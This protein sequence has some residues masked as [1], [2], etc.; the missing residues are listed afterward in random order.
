LSIVAAIVMVAVVV[1]ALACHHCGHCCHQHRCGVAAITIVGV[2]VCLWQTMLQLLL[3]LLS[4]AA[5][6]VLLPWPSLCGSW[7][8]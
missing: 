2:V 4:S 3:L 5:V 6:V 7:H 1:V 8:H